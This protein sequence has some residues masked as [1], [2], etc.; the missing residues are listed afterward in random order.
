MKIGFFPLDITYKIIDD[1]PIIQ[2]YGKT[3]KG[4]KIC[5]LDTIK[6]Y[7]LAE[8][9]NQTVIDQIKK[10]ELED[11]E[12]VIEIIPIE[13]NILGK[14]K[15]LIKIICSLPK[16]VPKIRNAIKEA[17]VNTYEYDI[18][19]TRRYLMDN[20]ITPLTKIEVE[21][22]EVISNL[23]V[24]CFQIKNI[25][26]TTTPIK[27]LNVLA[28]DIE[29]Y[30]P[31]GK[32]FIPEEHPILMIA[33]YGKKFKKVLTWK[34]FKDGKNVEFLDGEASLLKRFSEIIKEIKPDMITGYYSDGFD[35]PYINTRA[36]HHKL[37]LKLGLDG[38]ELYVRDETA[39][40]LGIPHIDIFKFIKRTMSQ[41]L[42]TTSYSLNDVSSELL[43]EKK[44]DVELDGLAKTWDDGSEELAV[45]AKYNMQD[46]KLTYD[47]FEKVFVNL[48]EMVKFVGL[49]PYDVNRMGFS[50]LVEWY[51]IKQT[52]NFNEII[53]NKPN[54]NQISDRRFKK[55]QGAFVFEPKPGLY[56]DIVI[57][58]FRSL[59]PTIITSHNISMS[60]LKCD[61][62]KEK[63][64]QNPDKKDIWFCENNKGF[65][66]KILEDVVRRR[67]RIKNMLKENPDDMLLKARV[68]ALKLLA[69]SF[70][71]YMGFYA[72]RWYC[73][74]CGESVT[75]FARNYIKKVIDEATNNGFKI[76]YSDTDSIFIT[77]E[78]KSKES[79]FKLVDN[80]NRELPE[81]MELEYEG[82]YP[83]GIFVS[84]KQGL[85]GA[86]KRYV[87]I[88]DKG[89]L[90]ITGFEAVRRNVSIIAKE[91]QEQ[92]F[93]IILKEKK[94]KKALEYVR[95]VID[96]LKNKKISNE[97][98]IIYTRLSKDLDKYDAIGPHVA[99]ARKMK[100]KGIDVGAGS[101][102]KYIICEGE[103]IIRDKA[104]ASD[105]TEQG[106]YD[107]DYYISHQVI[108][109]VEKVF[110]V[111]GYN[112]D[113]LI[114]DSKQKDLSSFF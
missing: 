87:L 98:V 74:E 58:D 90:K 93:N 81:L 83:A 27:D 14:K 43:N 85:L 70:Y 18:K 66:S 7:F 33:I 35:F 102:I 46:A 53:L 49:M 4:N 59:Y 108:P 32:K 31:L 94:K 52:I 60:S 112:K 24:P 76:I 79:A 77:L 80:I 28:I 78:G 12:K 103:G 91:T 22:N 26:P 50:Q 16:H 36:K 95:D 48:E 110:E 64:N 21:A 2:M 100:Q 30:N 6:P 23:Q 75:A 114:S 39:K 71:G 37:K 1:K 82:H 88:N 45:F 25:E 84:A 38:S 62:C 96:D 57:F 42:E 17:V 109:A 97:K 51:I 13:K 106:S 107:A 55:F 69:N 67:M 3:E 20:E 29:T 56:E 73:F 34:K 44:H 111:L 104:K 113:D 54:Y 105:E 9:E 89:N 68:G 99:V 41:S 101:T 5:L 8:V 86:K 40:I 61:C 47:L 92:V 19:Y 72:A 10:I 65:L 11:G 15:K 63:K